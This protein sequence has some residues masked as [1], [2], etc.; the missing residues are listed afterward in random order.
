MS[1]QLPLF[2]EG[3]YSIEGY[4]P[5][6][7]R[8]EAML[9]LRTWKT[10]RGKFRGLGGSDDDLVDDDTPVWNHSIKVLELVIYDDPTCFISDH[11][12]QF[13]RAA[14]M[15]NWW[16]KNPA[17][18]KRHTREWQWLKDN[19]EQL[20][21]S[22]RYWFARDHLNKIREKEA[23]VAAIQEALVRARYVQQLLAYEVL[24][25]TKLEGKAREMKWA[26]I[27]GGLEFSPK[28]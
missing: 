21:R 20:N 28:L 12:S 1:D 5:H 7:T 16:L 8:D 23:E 11:S 4:V 27:T 19:A 22:S 6:F 24:T 9:H 3:E 26:E 2:F 17:N 14:L 13:E 10:S 25:G 15:V 18:E